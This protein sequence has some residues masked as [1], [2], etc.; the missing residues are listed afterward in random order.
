[1]TE[2]SDAVVVIVSE[3]R[4]EVSLALSGNLEKIETAEELSTRLESLLLLPDRDEAHI[5]LMKRIFGNFWPKLAIVA[6]VLISWLIITARQGEIVTTTAQVQFRNLP[7]SLLLR[8]ASVEEV[9]L[10]LKTFSSL[11][12]LPKQG[13]LIAEIDLSKTRVGSNKILFRKEDFKLPSGVMITRISPTSFNVTMEK[14]VRKL[15]R[16]VPRLTGTLPAGLHL[17]KVT[18]EPSEVMMEGPDSIMARMGSVRTE[19]VRLSSLDASTTVTKKLEVPA[20]IRAI[21]AD[22]VSIQIQ[23]GS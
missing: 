19:E 12:Q 9:E 8:N 11:I 22:T 21:S 4:G 3:E 17:R 14:R 20:H 6:L 10:Q 13:E 23:L 15:V 7:D 5:T 1:L 18:V 16:V 2:R